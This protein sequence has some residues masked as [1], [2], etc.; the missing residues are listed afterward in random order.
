M[1]CS[2]SSRLRVLPA[3]LE[4]GAHTLCDP[5]FGAIVAV[6]IHVR[7]DGHGRVA[8]VFAHHGEWLSVVERR[9]QSKPALASSPNIF[10]CKTPTCLRSSACM[11]SGVI[12]TATSYRATPSLPPHPMISSR[13]FTTGCPSFCVEMLGCLVGSRRRSGSAPL[14]AD[15]VSRRGDECVSCFHLSH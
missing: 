11:T 6:A 3:L 7:R 1:C 2:T 12:S 10:I 13:P 14:I 5:P 15:A 8:N 4:N 9:R